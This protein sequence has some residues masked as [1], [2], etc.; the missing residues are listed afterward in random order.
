MRFKLPGQARHVRLF[1]R[2]ATTNEAYDIFDVGFEHP[3]GN[4]DSLAIGGSFATA[5]GWIKSADEKAGVPAEPAVQGPAPA[6]EA[7]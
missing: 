3:S 2:V 5:K 1:E 6:P 4:I 7:A